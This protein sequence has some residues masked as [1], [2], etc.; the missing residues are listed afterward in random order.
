M[1]FYFNILSKRDIEMGLGLRVGAIPIIMNTNI[2]STLI[3]HERSE[4]YQ[5]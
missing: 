4:S 2:K 5:R 3:W 1:V